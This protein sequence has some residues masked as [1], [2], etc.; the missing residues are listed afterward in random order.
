MP[1]QKGVGEGKP[2]QNTA[3][4]CADLRVDGL[5]K[6]WEFRVG[7]RNVDSLTG[8]AGEVGEALSDRKVDMACVQET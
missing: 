7:T 2:S 1:M 4:P 3:Q 8:G 6:G 5:W